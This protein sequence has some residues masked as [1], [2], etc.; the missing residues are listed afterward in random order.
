M[1]SLSVCRY[2]VINDEMGYVCHFLNFGIENLC[3]HTLC[4][5]GAKYHLVR[6]NINFDK[7]C[8]ESSFFDIGWVNFDHWLFLITAKCVPFQYHF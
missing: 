7:F 3:L 4:N 8:F 6:F 1:S 2:V 5:M